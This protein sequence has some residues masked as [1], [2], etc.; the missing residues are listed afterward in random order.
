MAGLCVFYYV[1]DGAVGPLWNYLTNHEFEAISTDARGRFRIDG[2]PAGMEFE[3]SLRPPRDG[4]VTHHV[5]KL[6]LK[7]GE[8]K[9]VGDLR[10]YKTGIMMAVQGSR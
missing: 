9:D 6:T 4:N 10:A 3:V 5:R 7:A 8:T 2:I 1:R